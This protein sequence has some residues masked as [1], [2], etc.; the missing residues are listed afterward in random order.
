M[1]EGWGSARYVLVIFLSALA[2]FAGRGLAER[3]GVTLSANPGVAFGL[4]GGA[5]VFAVIL[6]GFALTLLAGCVFRMKGL[7]NK[8]RLALSLMAGGAAA[9]FASRLIQGAVTDWIPLPFSSAF[10]HGGLRFNLADLEI[11]FGAAWA[12]WSW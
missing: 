6:S 9:N 7:N 1:F 8:T 10:F 2:E 12:L 5:P 4:F 3:W 11:A